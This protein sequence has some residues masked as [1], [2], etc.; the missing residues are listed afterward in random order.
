M[1]RAS[2]RLII[3]AEEIVDTEVIRRRPDRT[4]IPYSLVD[5]VI[6]APLG[7]HPGE[8]C[9]RYSRDEE[10]IRSWVEA[11][12]TPETTAEFLNKYIYAVTD[13]QAYL[14]LFGE[15][16]L[17]GLKSGAPGRES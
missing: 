15:A 1:A 12:K 16:R 11:S 13:H 7:S 3:S 9:Y 10:Q 14:G 6:E 17:E 4:I 8:M 2:K 5:A